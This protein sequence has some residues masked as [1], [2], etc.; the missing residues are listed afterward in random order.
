MSRFVVTGME[1]PL[2]LMVGTVRELKGEKAWGEEHVRE[3]RVVASP[4]LLTALLSHLDLLLAQEQSLA[5]VTVVIYLLQQLRSD[6]SFPSLTSSFIST[7]I[8]ST[9]HCNTRLQVLATLYDS[10]ESDHPLLYEV[11]KAICLY[12]KSNNSAT[13]VLPHLQHLQKTMDT[14][15]GIS[16]EQKADMYWL[17]YE[18]ASQPALRT[19]LVLHTLEH[20]EAT[21]ERVEKCVLDIMKLTNAHQLLKVL[22]LP[23]VAALKS[24]V[25]DLGRAISEGSVEAFE[26]FSQ[27]NSSFFQ[28]QEIDKDKMKSFLRI[29]AIC[30]IAEQSPLF[31]FQQAA[32]RIQVPE[33]EVDL[34]VVQAITS[35]LLEARIDQ[36]LAKVQVINTHHRFTSASSTQA[37]L[38]TFAK[39]EAAL[40]QVQA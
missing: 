27:A 36:G 24:P 21:G 19:T 20:S 17:A 26:Q 6:P 37:L 30:E 39:W 5:H 28:E 18:L 8:S 38:T 11:F 9:D 22:Q 35:G 14:W 29:F 23:V 16:K 4:Q 34:W 3:G 7:I 1:D 33:A 2:D 32:E 12:A 25:G 40:G 31:T 10:F 13:L 15:K